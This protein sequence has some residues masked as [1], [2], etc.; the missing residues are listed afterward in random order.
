MALYPLV[1]SIFVIIPWWAFTKFVLKLNMSEY[2]N[3]GHFIFLTFFATCAVVA[4]CDQLNHEN[5]GL[6]I[7]A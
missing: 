5:K 7:H 3:F 6:N 4:I 2:S 1:L